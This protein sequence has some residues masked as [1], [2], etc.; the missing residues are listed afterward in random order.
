MSRTILQVGVAAL[1]AAGPMAAQ[2]PSYDRPFGTLRDQAS[3]QQQW[4]EERLETVLPMLM[5]EHGIEMWVVPM[6]EYNEDPIFRALVSPTTFGARRRTIYV[7]HDH[8]PEEGVERLAFGGSSQ[9]GAYEAVRGAATTP[10]GRQQE[11]WGYAQWELFGEMVRERNPRNIGVNISRENAFADGLTAGE[12]EQMQEVLGPDLLRRIVR[13]EL[14]PTDYLSTRVPDMLPT[15]QKLMGLVHGI[16]STAFSNEV[17]LP[18][19]TTTEDVVWWMRQRINDYGLGTWFQPSVD[20]QRHGGLQDTGPHSPVIQRGDVLHCDIGVIA[21][22]L[23]TDTQHMAYVLRVGETEVP[24][25]LMQALR[26]GNRLQDIAMESMVPGLTGNEA[27]A[28][29]LASMRAAGIDG[30]VYSH[31][32]GDHGHASGSIIG[33]WDRQEGV[34]GRGDIPLRT[35]IY[36]SIELSATTPVPEWDGQRVRMG[37]EEDAEQTADGPM[38][39]ILHRQTEFHL[40]R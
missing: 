6:R 32:V 4:L 11:L 22:G 23:H 25:G 29:T 34:P 10:D 15:Y 8:G 28:A 31:P 40:V 18:G 20:V 1:I 21:L 17:I 5:R 2:T 3:I 9:G 30:S 38:K 26:N 13:A 37:L 12:W 36:W 39:W 7:F 24:E 19:V 33:L 14:L 35:N 27:L 16:I